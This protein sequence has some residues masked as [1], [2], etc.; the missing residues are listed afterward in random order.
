MRPAV[1]DV[2]ASAYAGTGVDPNADLA[3]IF[4]DMVVPPR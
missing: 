4:D 1:Q 3:M 2:D